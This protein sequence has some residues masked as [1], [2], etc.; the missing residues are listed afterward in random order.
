M[1]SVRDRRQRSDVSTAPTSKA[2]TSDKNVPVQQGRKEKSADVLPKRKIAENSAENAP[3][4]QGLSGGDSDSSIPG[5]LKKKTA[6]VQQGLGEGQADS[7]A[8]GPSPSGT[9]A[10]H[11]QKNGEEIKSPKKSKRSI[12]TNAQLDER[13]A[14]HSKQ[15][16]ASVA[17]RPFCWQQDHPQT[18]VLLR[19]SRKRRSSYP[20]LWTTALL[21]DL[22][23]LPN[24][25][26]LQRQRRI[27][28]Q[29]E[30]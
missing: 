19:L 20:L 11:K 6:P 23:R 10:P 4:Q 14:A 3:V 9:V 7:S 17:W 24:L 28:S 26:L 2:A 13:F 29:T 15:M 30:S 22:Q 21:V 18:L 1:S 25:A 27:Q 16:S 8:G 12:V 5:A